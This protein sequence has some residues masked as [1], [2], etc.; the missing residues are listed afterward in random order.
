MV[1][2]WYS[3]SRTGYPLQRVGYVL[4]PTVE[5]SE[6]WWLGGRSD[7][8]TARLVDS[9]PLTM[10]GASMGRPARWRPGWPTSL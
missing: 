7:S 5:L 10:T 8:P 4:E 2:A 9:A 3:E 6:D 1:Q